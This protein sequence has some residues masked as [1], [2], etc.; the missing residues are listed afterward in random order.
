MR[1]PIRY[2]RACNEELHADVDAY[3][4]SG[5]RTLNQLRVGDAILVYHASA[6]ILPSAP[7]EEHAWVTNTRIVRLN[8]LIPC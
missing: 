7:I 4:D 3:L 6:F 1:S 8:S 2:Q 5:T